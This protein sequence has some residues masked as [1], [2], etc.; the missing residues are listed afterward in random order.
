MRLV[1]AVILVLASVASISLAQETAPNEAA[2]NA[3]PEVDVLADE[4]DRGT[5]RRSLLGFLTA[6]QD[7]DFETAA[8]YLDRYYPYRAGDPMPVAAEE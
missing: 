6:A 7:R 4:F 5:P 1:P 3:A 2:Q 8:E